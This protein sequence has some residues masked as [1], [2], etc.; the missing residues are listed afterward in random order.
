MEKIASGHVRMKPKWFFVAGSLLTGMG[1]AG[2]TVSAIFLVNLTIFLIRRQGPGYGKLQM[3]LTTFPWWVLI[4]AVLVAVIGIILLKKYDFS[5]KKNFSL[6][7][8]VFISAIVIAALAI[9][10]SGLNDIWS[11]RGP[12]KRFYQQF[13]NHEYNYPKGQ[14]RIR[15]I[16]NS[17]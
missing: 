16:Q 15:R 9:D 7:I 3:M 14:G 2:L 6:I 17:N 11:Q 12:M 5:Y 13:V 4:L 1:L 10:Y 8:I